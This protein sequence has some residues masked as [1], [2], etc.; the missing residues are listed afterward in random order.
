MRVLISGAGGF[1][2]SALTEKLISSGH[3]V[4]RLT[5]RPVPSD[6]DAVSWDPRRG[7]LDA[8]DLEGIDAVVHLAGEG[9]GDHRWTEAHKAR[10]LDSRVRGT[11]LLAETIGG[12]E[13]PP[14][15]M[16]SQS[17]AHYYGFEGGDRFFTEDDPPGGGFL[18]R[19]VEQWEAATEPA[20]E[21]GIRVLQTRSGVVLSPDG[22]ALRKQLLV[23]KLGIGGKLGSGRQYFSWISLAD[24]V[25]AMEFLLE[26]DDI[27]GPVILASPNPVTNAEFT[28]ALGDALGRPTFMP[29]P[30]LAIKLMFSS[31]MS[32]EMIFG[33]QRLKPK[34]LLEAGFEFVDPEVGA[35]L[36]RMLD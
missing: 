30:S 20:A 28:R 4:V 2:G 6:R 1:I 24:E 26:R 15:V 23:F 29:V 18:A 11:H 32:D 9:I 16:L 5:R 36:R 34:R 17:G 25:A 7:R 33:G 19:V 14:Q 8:G 22:G 10:V 13:V 21:A 31:E 12:L 27:S 35:A 3:R